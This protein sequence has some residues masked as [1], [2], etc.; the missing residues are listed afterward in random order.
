MNDSSDEEDDTTGSVACTIGN[1]VPPAGY[2]I[3][4]ECPPLT[5]K[6]EKNNMIGETV[7]HGWDSNNATGWFV[8]TVQSRNLSAT[9]LKKTPTANFV[10]KYTAKMTDSALNGNVA[11]E[12]TART[13][14]P[15]EWWVL[16][17][18]DAATATS[19]ARG[20]GRGR[21]R[22]TGKG[23]AGMKRIS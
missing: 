16:V 20:R 15:A 14:E 1:A 11:C 4:D 22:G 21:G 17:E 18:K 8:G 13:H 9:D 12:L 5:T 2:K 7:L 10:M 6:R 3:V 23:K 19:A